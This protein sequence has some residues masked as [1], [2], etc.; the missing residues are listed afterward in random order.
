MSR[1]GSRYGAGRPASR[2]KDEV[3]YKI[4]IRSLSKFGMLVPG[5]RWLYWTVNG[6]QT[7][8]T[9]IW[10]EED[11]FK[12][13]FTSGDKIFKLSRTKCHFGGTRVWV[14]CPRCQK[15]M[16]VLYLRWGYFACRI[17]QD[18]SYESQSGGSDE[19]LALKFHKLEAALTNK[20]FRG[21]RSR[22]FLLNKMDVVGAAFDSMIKRY[23]LTKMP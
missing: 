23:E 5:M 13:C 12:L 18:I 21:R 8:K 10:A 11:Y 22:N 9:C 2:L 19:R 6:K 17:C 4:D 20:D 3:A 7:N 16:A 14:H 1:G 15:R